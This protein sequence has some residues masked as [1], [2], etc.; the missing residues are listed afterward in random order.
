MDADVIES[1]GIDEEE[2]KIFRE[3]RLGNKEFN[4][5]HLLDIKIEQGP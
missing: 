4:L 3:E 5:R 2:S 1:A